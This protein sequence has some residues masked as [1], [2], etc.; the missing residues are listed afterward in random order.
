MATCHVHPVA[1][2]RLLLA[3]ENSKTQSSSDLNL[4]E[5]TVSSSWCYT[6]HF[7]TL[8]VTPS[9]TLEVKFFQEQWT[10]RLC[11]NLKWLPH[12]W[13]VFFWRHCLQNNIFFKPTRLCGIRPSRQRYSLR[14]ICCSHLK[15]TVFVLVTI[16]GEDFIFVRNVFV[17][18][19]FVVKFR[20][21]P[22]SPALTFIYLF[23]RSTE[24]SEIEEGAYIYLLFNLFLTLRKSAGHT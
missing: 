10:T 15:D 6:F 11:I 19:A 14:F 24:Y 23:S 12:R 2:Y 9:R 22:V 7:T 20:P 13:D 3:K 5:D 1:L 21:S 8:N 18:F 16:M 4:T 17:S